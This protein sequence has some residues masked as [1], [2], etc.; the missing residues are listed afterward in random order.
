ME[1]V[2][3]GRRF[4]T[5]KRIRRDISQGSG[6]GGRTRS[7]PEIIGQ[8]QARPGAVSEWEMK[9]KGT[10]KEKTEGKS[11]R[12]NIRKSGK[13]KFLPRVELDY[14]QIELSS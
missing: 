3:K 14:V 5:G 1:R 7:W 10:T 2:F 8:E 11:F 4:K 6:D 9:R 13:F 12:R